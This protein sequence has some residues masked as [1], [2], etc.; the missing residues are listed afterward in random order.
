MMLDD[1]KSIELSKRKKT[2]NKHALYTV[3]TGNTTLLNTPKKNKNDNCWFQQNRQI[4][5]EVM[6]VY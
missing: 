4:T 2:Q 5:L 6:L 1:Q 3:V